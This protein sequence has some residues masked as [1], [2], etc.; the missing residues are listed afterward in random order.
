MSYKRLSGADVWIFLNGHFAILAR[1]NMK[2]CSGKAV[3]RCLVRMIALITA[4][5]L[6]M[7]TTPT[8]A[9]DDVRPEE[10]TPLDTQRARQLYQLIS[11]AADYELWSTGSGEQAVKRVERPVLRWSNPLRV[12]DDGAVFLW[13]DRGRPAAALCIY[14]YGIDGIDHEWQSLSQRPL[15][16]NYRQTLVWQPLAAGLEFHAVPGASESPASTPARRL[17]QMRQT[18]DDFTA[19][20]SYETG[21]HELRALTQP[22]Y[23][24]GDPASE[25]LDGAIFAFAEATDP[26]VLLLFEAHKS[27]EQ[28]AYW[29]WAAARMSMVHIEVKHRGDV[30]WEVERWDGRNNTNQPYITFSYKRS[31]QPAAR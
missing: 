19:T 5:L 2:I 9:Q 8:V 17:R 10:E 1:C 12:T 6:F 28:A 21:Q 24:Y 26:E 11:A 7:E 3:N 16:A 4:G 22:I 20:I 27:G 18:L 15:R 29:R 31:E 25:V 14:S 13:L 30:V 23:R